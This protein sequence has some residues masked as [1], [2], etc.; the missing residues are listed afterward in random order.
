MAKKYNKCAA[1]YQTAKIERGVPV[2]PKSDSG[3]K[4]L[5]DSMQ[6]GDS[7]ELSMSAAR[8]LQAALR[9]AKFSGVL[10]TTTPGK[11][12]VWKMSAS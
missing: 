9:V 3:I 1:E 12:R 10:R 7:V 5:V 4:H 8:S 11:A 2:P 6:L